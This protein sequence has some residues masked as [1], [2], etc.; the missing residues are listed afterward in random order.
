MKRGKG[1]KRGQD[2]SVEIMEN[3]RKSGSEQKI[4]KEEQDSL[5]KTDTKRR[6][7]IKIN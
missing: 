5:T 1:V 4:K 2:K 7:I 3:I 6:K